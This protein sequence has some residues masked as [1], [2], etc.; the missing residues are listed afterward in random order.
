[1]KNIII[2]VCVLIV[3]GLLTAC[4]GEEEIIFSDEG[5]KNPDD[6]YAGDTL[7]GEAGPVEKPDYAKE[8]EP[9]E[10]AYIYVCGAVKRPG[11]YIM[12]KDS[13][14]YMAI[15]KA[16]GVSDGA[17]VSGLNLASSVSDGM[18]IYVPKKGESTDR[19]KAGVTDDG[20]VNINTADKEKLMTIKGIGESR[21]EDIIAYRESNGLFGKCED[22]KNVNGIKDGLYNKIKDQIKV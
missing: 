9:V 20:L 15:E 1:M 3:A 7:S 2:S 12:E 22:I 11:V 14:I 6:V 5:S 13:R 17:D 19:A 8:T 18:E 16:G 4:S 10:E 21:A